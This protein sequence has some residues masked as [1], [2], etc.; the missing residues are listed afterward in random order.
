LCAAAAGTSLLIH[1]PEPTDLRLISAVA[2]FFRATACVIAA[3]ITTSPQLI[4]LPISHML[5]EDGARGSPEV[6]RRRWRVISDAGGGGGDGMQWQDLMVV[7]SKALHYG[8]EAS[9]IIS[10]CSSAAK[11]QSSN[12]VLAA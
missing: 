11:V 6:T 8:N 5:R 4:L 1:N 2:D 9:A 3:A 12:S 7:S 10:Y